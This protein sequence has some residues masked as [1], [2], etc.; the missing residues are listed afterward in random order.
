MAFNEYL[1]FNGVAL[2]FPDNYGISLKN[3]EA[4]TNGE[5]E[6][7]TTQR[8]IIR[9]GVVTIEVSFLL[10]HKWIGEMTEYSK[11]KKLYV[12]YFNTSTLDLKFTEM[13]ISDFKVNLAKD[14]SQKGL[15]N[16]TF[17]LNE[18]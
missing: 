11:Q 14:T 10:S 8:D 18:F 12:E 1:K 9:F 17:T 15:W 7:G 4:S 3:I 5:T 2:P 13:Y 16:V 6:A